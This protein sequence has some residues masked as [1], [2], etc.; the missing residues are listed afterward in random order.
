MNG[1]YDLPLPLPFHLPPLSISLPPLP[2]I[3]LPFLFNLHVLLP[4]YRNF[5]FKDGRYVSILEYYTEMDTLKMYID[6]MVTLP[7]CIIM[8]REWEQY[9][10]QQFGL[11]EPW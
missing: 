11:F 6:I 5:V 10:W 2:S 3:S 8:L 9:N 4:L 1:T 7:D